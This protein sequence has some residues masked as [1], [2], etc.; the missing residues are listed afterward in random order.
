[1]AVGRGH[2]M[3]QTDGRTDL[4]T[5][6]CLGAQDIKSVIVF[7]WLRMQSSVNGRGVCVCFRTLTFEPDTWLLIW[8]ILTIPR[9][10][11]RMSRSELKVEGQRKQGSH[12]E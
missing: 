6:L 1:M 5:A 11:T 12:V 10:Q 2:I 4:S 3:G 7:S 8:F 9:G